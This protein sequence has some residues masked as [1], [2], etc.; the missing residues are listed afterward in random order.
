MATDFHVL[1]DVCSTGQKD[2]GVIG[3]DFDRSTRAAVLSP[4]ELG[5]NACAADDTYSVATRAPGYDEVEHGPVDQR[6]FL[7]E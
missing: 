5:L 3:S 2:R 6:V 4:S 1:N 7:R